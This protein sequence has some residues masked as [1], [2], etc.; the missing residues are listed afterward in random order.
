V[1]TVIQASDDKK[2][3][4]KGKA[5][6]LSV[7]A[8]LVKILKEEGISGYYKGFGASMLNTFSMREWFQ[9]HHHILLD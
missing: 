6:S 1:K 3:K 5:G 4:G 7:S 9:T 2:G 8:L